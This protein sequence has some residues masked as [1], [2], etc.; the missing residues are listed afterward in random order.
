MS[1]RDKSTRL[2][3]EKIVGRITS[4]ISQWSSSM[5]RSEI[6]E[7]LRMRPNQLHTLLNDGAERCNLEYLLDVWERCGGSYSV[8]LTHER[9]D[10]KDDSIAT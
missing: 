1:V 10:E 3:R 7:R 2:E 6:C 9:N 8:V 4:C 5:N